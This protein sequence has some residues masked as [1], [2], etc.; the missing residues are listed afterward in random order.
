MSTENFSG[1]NRTI[2]TYATLEMS[3]EKLV[4]PFGDN[5]SLDHWI[6]KLMASRM[7]LE[8]GYLPSGF[9]LEKSVTVK[10]ESL[11]AD[12]LAEKGDTPVWVECRNCSVEKLTLVAQNFHG[13]IIHIDNFSWAS[14]EEIEA[15]AKS[16]YEWYLYMASGST[17]EPISFV[18][19]V[20]NWQ[21]DLRSPPNW[22]VVA[23]EDGTLMFLEHRNPEERPTALWSFLRFSYARACDQTPYTVETLENTFVPLP[24]FLYSNWQPNYSPQTME[25][26]ERH[27]RHP[28]DTPQVSAEERAPRLG[29]LVELLLSWGFPPEGI[30]IRRKTRVGRRNFIPY[31]LAAKSDTSIWVERTFMDVQKL[32]YVRDHF[33]GKIM[34]FPGHVQW[35]IF[36]CSP[37]WFTAGA[38][39]WHTFQGILTGWGIERTTDGRL[40]VFRTPDNKWIPWFA[41]DLLIGRDL[42]SKWEPSVKRYGEFR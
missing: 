26:L 6:L 40:Q 41:L 17:H 11:R 15:Q 22:G 39:Y 4:I 18:P 1:I 3:G 21:C 16:E 19:G 8:Q 38:E 13:R 10:G 9:D 33:G 7:L 27:K 25:V 34:V 31:V 36:G 14:L 12:I 28:D 5:E 23:S 30:S 29:Y 32:S 2:R 24:R 42:A 20:E 37:D 35:S